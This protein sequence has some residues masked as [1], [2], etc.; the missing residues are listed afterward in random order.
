MQNPGNNPGDPN[1]SSDDLFVR[2]LPSKAFIAAKQSDLNFTE[3]CLFRAGMAGV[4]GGGMGALFGLFMSSTEPATQPTD[5][6]I[7][8]KEM[9]KATARDM[10]RG[11]KSYAKTFAICGLTFSLC[12]CVIE[13]EFARK[14]IYTTIGAGCGAGAVLGVQ[15]GP[16][17][18][19]MGCVG[20]A[21]FSVLIDLVMDH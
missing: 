13:K 10:G 2:M 1:R 9:L 8:S 14:D 7:L 17:G 3:S 20:F 19:A 4:A 21:A 12:E 11:M 18:M 5:G 16:Q 15:G 6:K